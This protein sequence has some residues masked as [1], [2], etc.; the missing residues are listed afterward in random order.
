MEIEEKRQL[1]TKLFI[2]GFYPYSKVV[3]GDLKKDYGIELTEICRKPFNGGLSYKPDYDS[4][5]QGIRWIGGEKTLSW[6]SN[7]GWNI[8]EDCEIALC[9]VEYDDYINFK[10][11]FE[12]NS[13]EIDILFDKYMDLLKFEVEKFNFKPTELRHLIGRLGEI[14]CA[15]QVNGRLSKVVNSSGFDVISSN[16][17]R[18]SVKTTAQNASFV[19]LNKKTMQNF[20][21]LM[22][23]QLKDFEFEIL[24]FD[25]LNKIIEIA[26]TWSGDESKYE[27][28][29]NRL[30]KLK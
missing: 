4:S 19:S 22:I 13:N 2:S 26:H 11:S 6:G 5:S 27:L 9:R 30:S 7:T 15:K 28:Y 29:L 3:S 20:D 25:D 23:L 24:Y 1:L 21:K 16:N 12:S 18:I 14:F 17:E 10:I 8:T